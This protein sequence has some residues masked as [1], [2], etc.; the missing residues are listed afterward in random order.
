ML[1][2]WF[3]CAAEAIAQGLLPDWS[4]TQALIVL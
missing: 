2:I 3:F 4:T 1:I